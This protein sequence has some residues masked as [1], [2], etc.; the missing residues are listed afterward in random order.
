MS[1]DVDFSLFITINIIMAREIEIE[2]SNQ[3]DVIF[4]K[5]LKSKKR[6]VHKLID[7]L[8]SISSNYILIV[9]SYRDSAFVEELQMKS[10]TSFVLFSLFFC[11]SL[12]AIMS[13]HINIKISLERAEVIDHVKS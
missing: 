3:S 8:F 4:S 13:K 9:I 11:S 7:D 12:L 10:Q 6:D 5:I 2:M 1:Q